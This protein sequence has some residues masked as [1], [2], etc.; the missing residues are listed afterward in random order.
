VLSTE[1]IFQCRNLSDV[2]VSATGKSA[3]EATSGNTWEISWNGPYLRDIQTVGGSLVFQDGWGN[4][5]SDGNFGWMFD[6]TTSPN[7]LLIQSKGLDGD[8]IGTDV[9]EV[10]YPLAGNYLVAA[11]E[12]AH[13]DY[14]NGLV[15]SVAYCV[16]TVTKT[17]DL[18]YSDSASC[19]GVSADYIWVDYP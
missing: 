2:G 10:D 7:S 16:N 11:V 5:S 14:L 1:I 6:D 18:N 9:Y 3:C 17:I 13:I 19:E 4:S 12:T 15:S 8:S